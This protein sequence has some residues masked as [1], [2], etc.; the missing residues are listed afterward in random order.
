MHLLAL[1]QRSSEVVDAG[2]WHVTD[3]AVVPVKAYTLVM[4]MSTASRLSY[5]RQERILFD[6]LFKGDDALIVQNG[7]DFASTC[8]TCLSLVLLLCWLL[9]RL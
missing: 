6:D 7:C 2:V 3:K 9:C 4:H 5:R 8:N 1:A